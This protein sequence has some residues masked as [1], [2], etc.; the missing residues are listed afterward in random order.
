MDINKLK[1]IID[2]DVHENEYWDFKE[3]WYAKKR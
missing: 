3:K 1:K 2:S